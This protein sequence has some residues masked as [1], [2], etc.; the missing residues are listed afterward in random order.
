MSR[1]IIALVSFGLFAVACNDAAHDEHA[2][3][4]NGYAPAL[5]TREDTLFHEVMKGHDAGMAVLGKLRGN[6]KETASQLDSLNK[7]PAKKVDAAYKQA[8]T[9]LH[10]DLTNADT[11]MDT[12]MQQFK[13]DSVA[14][15]KELRIKYLE[16]ERNK[17]T[18]VKEHIFSALQQ[19]DSLL[20]RQ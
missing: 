13:L 18:T 10:T 11:E 7:L 14:D 3:H 6:I 1:F 19:A 5:K 12:W 2:E 4:K 9:S 15:N 17:V 8:L 20:K 16:G